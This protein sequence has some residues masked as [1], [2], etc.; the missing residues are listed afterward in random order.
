MRLCM[1]GRHD[2]EKMEEL[3]R[4]LFSQVEDK[5]VVVPDLNTPVAYDSKNLAHIHRFIP[6]KDK[7]ILSFVWYLPS[8][9]SEYKS[10]PLRYHS[11]LF[12]HEGENSLLSFLIAEGLALELSA[13][14][15]HELNGAFSNF[16]VDVT[17]TK[18]GLEQYERVVEA[19]F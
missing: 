10:Q 1:T 5:E 9:E 12:G 18:K 4:N 13:S 14:H 2:I 17:L 15:D 8:S 11:H 3:A 6:V 16:N 7:D 19:V